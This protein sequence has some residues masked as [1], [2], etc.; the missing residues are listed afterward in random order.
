MIS[1]TLLFERL[2]DNF[3]ES[4]YFKDLESR[5]IAINKSCAEKFGLKSPEEAINKTDFNFFA[6]EHAQKAMEDEQ[7]IMATLQPII[8]IEEREVFNDE[9]RTVKWTSTSK[10]P[11]FDEN[12]ELIGTYGIT[13]DITDEKQ[14]FEE[15]RRLK[16]QVESILNTVPSMI[17]VKDLHGRYIM[18]NKAAKEYFDP[19][20]LEIIGKT[21]EELGISKERA[22]R[23]TQTDQKVIETQRPAFYAEEKTTD[24]EGNDHW[25]Q[26]IKVPFSQAEKDELAAL[27]V[28]TDVTKRIEYEAELTESL[29]VIQKQ[30]ERL[31]NFAH[32]VSHNLRNHAGGISMLIE[33][34]GDAQTPSEK[35]ELFDLLTKASNRLNE[36]IADLNEIMDTQNKTEVELKNINFKSTLNGIK[37]VLETEIRVN[38]AT[39]E[40][41]IEADLTFIYS[42]AYLE[43]ILLNLITNAIKYKGE[44]A[45]HIKLKVWKEDERTH[46]IIEDNG[47]GIN[48][49]KHGDKLF[50]MYKTFHDN[51]NAKGIGLYIT[52]NQIEA[53]GGSITVESKPNEGTMFTV[54][55]GEQREKK[56]TV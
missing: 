36:T 37:E 49:E 4:V 47:R 46:M 55:F 3:T 18:A 33:L 21:D 54:D 2:M 30:N 48:L 17:F 56:R 8:N 11:L 15:I 34:V 7:Q 6:I 9:A 1:K 16:E 31:S 40:E 22:E 43:S 24:W 38:D 27:S 53:L 10:F 5:F 44:E 35:R 42:P 28:I 50:G 26:T 52:K 23:Y 25:H 13:K 45:P 29:N 20:K 14:H 39:F 41:E 51:S 12:N 32:I 19:K